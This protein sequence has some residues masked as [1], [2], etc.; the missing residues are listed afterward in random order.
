MMS[1]RLFVQTK[2]SLLPECVLKINSII[3]GL[4]SKKVKFSNMFSGWKLWNFLKIIFNVLYKWNVECTDVTIIFWHQHCNIT[5]YV[6]SNSTW[7]VCYHHRQHHPSILCSHQMIIYPLSFL[8]Y[9]TFSIRLF[10]ILF[11]YFD[12]TLSFIQDKRISKSQ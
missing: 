8:N 11:I 7:T 2:D 3:V 5:K 4:S 6:N 1:V 9:L 12:V 10:F